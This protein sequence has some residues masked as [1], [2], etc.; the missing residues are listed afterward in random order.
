MNKRYAL[1]YGSGSV[2]KRKDVYW[3]FYRD[4]EGRIIQETS[5]TSD[6]ASAMVMLIDRALVTAQARVAV[7]RA[8]REEAKA[9][10]T[11]T[12]RDEALNRGEQG[13][14]RGSVRADAA[15]RGAGRA[16][17]RGGKS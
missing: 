10:A 11:A 17:N 12:G 1:P 9:A 2:R 3:L 16:A 7:L 13:A 5:H 14:R 15:R 4:P 8:A 6:Y